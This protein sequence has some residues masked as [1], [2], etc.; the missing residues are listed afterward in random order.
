MR[1]NHCGLAGKSS[2]SYFLFLHLI[3]ALMVFFNRKWKDM[4]I[5]LLEIVGSVL[6]ARDHPPVSV[7]FLRHYV[8]FRH[9][10]CF[11]P[12]LILPASQYT[13]PISLQALGRYQN[14]CAKPLMHCLSLWSS[15]SHQPINAFFTGPNG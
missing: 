6:F 1:F 9:Y 8:S 2:L 14:L 7:R 3:S 15:V 12:H 4:C 5:S 11:F 13:L 10:R